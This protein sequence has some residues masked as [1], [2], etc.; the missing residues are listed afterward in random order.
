MDRAPFS[1]L[2]LRD[3]ALA[4]MMAMTLL[5]RLGAIDQMLATKLQKPPP[6]AVMM[7]LRLGVAQALFMDTPAFAAVDTDS[8]AWA[9]ADRRDLRPFK[10]LINAVLRGRCCAEP[11]P[12]ADAVRPQRPRP[13]CSPAGARPMAS[14]RPRP[15]RP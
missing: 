1:D 14:P 3:R 8:A 9:E 15:S 12:E 2:E 13:G 7:L 10:G 4:R 11:P 5:R 6:M